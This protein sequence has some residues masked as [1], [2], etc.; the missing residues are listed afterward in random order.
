[1]DSKRKKQ[2]KTCTENALKE[3]AQSTRTRTTRTTTISNLKPD[4][5]SNIVSFSNIPDFLTL[6]FVDHD[7]RTIASEY[8]PW[9]K[10]LEV[11]E[12]ANCF[13]KC[14]CCRPLSGPAGAKECECSEKYKERNNWTWL[15]D[16][17]EVAKEA[18]LKTALQASLV[19]H[20]HDNHLHDLWSF[21][22]FDPRRNPLYWKESALSRLK[23]MVMF[24][25]KAAKR[26]GD[27]LLHDLNV[28]LDGNGGAYMTEDMPHWVTVEH[29][30]DAYQRTHDFYKS[31]YLLS[32]PSM[33]NRV[34]DYRICQY[35][36]NSR[37]KPIKG[38]MNSGSARLNVM[39]DLIDSSV[40]AVELYNSRGCSMLWHEHDRYD[41]FTECFRVHEYFGTSIRCAKEYYFEGLYGIDHWA[42]EPILDGVPGTDE[43]FMYMLNLTKDGDHQ[44]RMINMFG[45]DMYESS[46][47]VHGSVRKNW[48]QLLRRLKEETEREDAW[49]L[50]HDEISWEDRVDSAIESVH[51][52]QFWDDEE[53]G[54]EEE[55]EE[56]EEESEG[57]ASAEE[58]EESE[59]DDDDDDDDES[60]FVSSS[61][62][63]SG[64]LML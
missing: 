25:R 8:P 1:M 12:N 20:S 61:Y 14:D 18:G 29:C 33:K 54:E 30:G 15:G 42:D 6:L 7:F 4:T 24:T 49:I 10:A 45:M 16:E 2:G 63:V 11:L 3:N 50:E 5:I 27:N 38:D 57:E 62:T 56:E 9:T 19:G 53:I 21:R 44:E 60:V 28:S 46:F 34:S 22:R 39:F 47:D 26:L 13:D 64:A 59:D 37:R 55:S 32:K 40:A 43:H 31:N 52:K 23:K 41:Y 58:E 48:P 17:K 35:I 36:Y 51:F